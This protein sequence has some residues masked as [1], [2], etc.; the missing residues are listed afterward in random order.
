M[1]KIFVI[2]RGDALYVYVLLPQRGMTAGVRF[3]CRNEHLWRNGRPEA[4]VYIASHIEWICKNVRCK[5]QAKSGGVDV[6][7]CKQAFFIS[8]CIRTICYLLAYVR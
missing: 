3:S 1:R 8:E 5:M 4:T 6:N 7:M 2:R